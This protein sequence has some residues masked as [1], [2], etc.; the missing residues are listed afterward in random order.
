MNALK[1]DLD[2]I[3][4]VRTQLDHL[5]A[6]AAVASKCYRTNGLASVGPFFRAFEMYSIVL[7]TAHVYVPASNILTVAVS[8]FVISIPGH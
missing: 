2:A 3:K 1:G 7:T 6:N 8:P 5:S 4:S